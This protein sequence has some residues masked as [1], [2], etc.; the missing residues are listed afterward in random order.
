MKSYLECVY[1]FWQLDSRQQASRRAGQPKY[2]LLLMQVQIYYT[3]TYSST[4]THSDA[5]THSRP[6]DEQ[7]S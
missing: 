7:G 5:D 2:T 6:Q 1:L 3:P 4:N